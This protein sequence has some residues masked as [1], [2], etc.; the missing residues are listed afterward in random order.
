MIMDYTFKTP[1]K[2]IEI[3]DLESLDFKIPNDDIH[4]FLKVNRNKKNSAERCRGNSL[5]E[6]AV[7][8]SYKHWDN[9]WALS[10]ANL[11]KGMKVL[12]SGSGRGVFQF[13][14]ASKGIEVHANDI[15]DLRSG[16]V[17]KF[18][19]IFSKIGLK[20]DLNPYKVHKKL[21][22]K[23]G[24][25]VNFEHCGTEKLPYPD[26]YFD[27]VFSISV[28]EHMP[29]EVIEKSIQEMERVLKPNGLFLLTF[30]YH[31]EH[32]SEETGFTEKTFY[33]KVVNKCSLKIVNNRP[34]FDVTD[35]NAYIKNIN[36]IFRTKN[37]N[38]SFGV[39]FTK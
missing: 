4:N 13:Y 24:V 28:I 3:S 15:S 9:P 30:D 21:N 6:P 23:Y 33:D 7:F 22:K 20:F 39:V 11:S 5:L 29:N 8:E 32:S 2:L 1:N 35:W 12:D 17:K 37:N 27:R 26:D 25:D 31:P 34:N 19:N 38:T 18:N 10:N 14:L 36:T 16:S